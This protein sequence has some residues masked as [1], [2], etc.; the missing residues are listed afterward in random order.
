MGIRNHFVFS[1]SSLEWKALTSVN[2][3]CQECS[4]P[5]THTLNMEL[6]SQFDN[7]GTVLTGILVTVFYCKRIPCFHL[8]CSFFPYPACHLPLLL[9]TAGLL[10]AIHCRALQC[11]VASIAVCSKQSYTSINPLR[12][13]NWVCL[14]L[15]GV[16][17]VQPVVTILPTLPD[18]H[19]TSGKKIL[20]TLELNTQ[21][22]GGWTKVIIYNLRLIIH[23]YSYTSK[24]R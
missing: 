7:C 6:I 10:S 9:L 17:G 15:P 13:K 14:S 24:A 20:L 11:I 23:R 8:G 2:A 18:R 21:A 16:T 12:L 4:Q 3:L 1:V 5:L 22:K 19:R